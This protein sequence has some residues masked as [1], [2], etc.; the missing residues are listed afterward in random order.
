MGN[1]VDAESHKI[2]LLLKID[3]QNLFDRIKLKREDY[4]GIFAI[5]RTRSHFKDIFESRYSSLGLEDLKKCSEETVILLDK[6]YKEVGEIRWYLDHTEDMPA[7][8]EDK[9]NQ[10]IKEL[11]I[12]FNDL[13]IHLTAELEA[14]EK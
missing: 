10:H 3:S 7:T 13:K 5:K 11:E 6:F 2:L 9:I 14:K 12:L 4:L 8:V 1:R